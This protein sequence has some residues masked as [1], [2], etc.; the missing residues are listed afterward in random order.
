MPKTPLRKHAQNMKC[1]KNMFLSYIESIKNRFLVAVGHIKKFYLINWLFFGVFG[2]YL[3][4]FFRFN[5]R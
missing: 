4:H 2:V 5:F 1:E 3:G